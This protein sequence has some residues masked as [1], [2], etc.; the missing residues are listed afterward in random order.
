[1]DQIERAAS[2]AQRVKSCMEGNRSGT[3]PPIIPKSGW[4]LPQGG[5]VT[6]GYRHRTFFRTKMR[7]NGPCKGLWA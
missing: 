7:R 4:V 2:R 1:M 3:W 5:P 6:V